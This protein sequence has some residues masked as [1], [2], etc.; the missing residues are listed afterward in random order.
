M[1]IHGEWSEALD[2]MQRACQILSKP[3][4]E[5]AAGEAYYQLAEIFRLRGDF[6]QAEKL[7][8]EA[9]KWGRKP[10]PG[11]ALLRLAQNEKN[12]AIKSI[13]NAL[14]EAKSSPEADKNFTGLHRN[15]AGTR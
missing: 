13:Q 8:V 3:P 7:Y 6:Q 14:D 2:E 4:G 12:L 11:M 9:N 10:Q 15:H 1:H 5:P